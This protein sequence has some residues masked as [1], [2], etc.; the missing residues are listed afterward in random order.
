MRR[1]SAVILAVTLGLALGACGG[2]DSDDGATSGSPASEDS[3][4]QASG[5]AI[6]DTPVTELASGETVSVRQTAAADKP[7]LYWFWAPY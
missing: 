3:G 6:P 1:R 2:D 7:T 4:E 5:A